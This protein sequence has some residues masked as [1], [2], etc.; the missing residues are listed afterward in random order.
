MVVQ[1][2]ADRQV[3]DRVDA[4]RAELVGGP[5]AAAQ[6]DRRAPVHAR[7]HD[8]EVGADLDLTQRADRSHPDRAAALDD[9][10][11]DGRVAAHREVR[12]IAHG[13]EVGEGR[14][15]A[16]AV[17]TVRRLDADPEPAVERVE[18]V[19]LRQSHR[20]AGL[21]ELPM[22][23]RDLVV[24]EAAHAHARG[25]LV[26][27]R[28]QVVGRPALEPSRRPS[29]VVGAMAPAD[30]AAVVGGTP[31]DH[32][33]PLVGELASGKLVARRVSP[34]VRD[35]DRA[36]VEEFFRPSPVGEGAVVGPGFDQEHAAPGFDE[37]RRDDGPGRAA[38][39][40]DRVVVRH[41]TRL[42]RR[43]RVGRC[44]VGDRRYPG[45]I[46]TITPSV[47]ISTHLTICRV[48]RAFISAAQ[49][50]KRSRGRRGDC[51]RPGI[52][53]LGGGL[54]GQ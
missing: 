45:R 42:S 23:R 13:I 9:H 33:G 53:G 24:G 6:Q 16:D 2:A 8:D 46:F 32:A 47:P 54:C 37:T 11:V 31:A 28:E 41:T 51:P 10:P 27:E 35:R 49:R 39:A 3:D 30:R 15:P 44:R 40:H 48:S 50:C 22:E 7:A 18:V 14:V 38:A 25:R 29:V 21:D 36:G 17:G 20:G 12:T 26:E 5:D 52:A 43:G 34:V 1:V 19:G 4:E